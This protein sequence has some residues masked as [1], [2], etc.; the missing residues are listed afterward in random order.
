MANQ[1]FEVTRLAGRYCTGVALDIAVP[2][3]MVAIDMAAAIDMR[4]FGHGGSGE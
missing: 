4:L 2:S 3:L 1:V